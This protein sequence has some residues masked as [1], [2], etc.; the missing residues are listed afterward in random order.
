LEI[1][2]LGSELKSMNSELISAIHQHA[3][4]NT[5]INSEISSAQQKTMEVIQEIQVIKE[6][7]EKSESLVYEMCKDIKSLDIAKKNL[8]FSIT[9][10]KKFIMMIT[11]INKL[12][13]EQK[14]EARN[15]KETSNLISAFDELAIYFKKY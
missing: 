9:T 5:Q 7:A 3:L 6:K 8:T 2:Q 14:N 1:D 4:M 12:V 13:E 10:L 11:A 15:Y